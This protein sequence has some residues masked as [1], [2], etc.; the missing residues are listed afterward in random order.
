MPN[1]SKVLKFPEVPDDLVRHFIRGY[2][3]GDGCVSYRLQL[4][5]RYNKLRQFLTIRFICGNRSF[6]KSLRDVL[7]VSAQVGNGSISRANGSYQ[8]QYAMRDSI[9]FF[10][11]FYKGVSKNCY[12]ERKHQALKLAI[13]KI[14]R[15]RSVAVNIPACHAGDRGFE[16][17]R[18]RKG[19]P[20]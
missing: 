12:L 11:Y 14:S 20:S 1:K 9:I 10:G 15:G 3:D 6:L 7:Q 8:L 4:D 16:S 13:D 19:S 18:S 5:K 17:R 2:F